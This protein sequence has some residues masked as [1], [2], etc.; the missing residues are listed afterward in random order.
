MTKV[1]TLCSKPKKLRERVF[2]ALSSYSFTLLGGRSSLPE[3][4][5]CTLLYSFLAL[6]LA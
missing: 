1:F 2:H 4:H 6:P 3:L 5:S